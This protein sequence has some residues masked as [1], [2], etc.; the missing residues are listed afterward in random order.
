MIDPIKWT[1]TRL[2]WSVVARFPDGTVWSSSGGER[3]CFCAEWTHVKISLMT[4]GSYPAIGH[5]KTDDR[6]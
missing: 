5:D 4:G 1:T 3:V 2:D 6:T